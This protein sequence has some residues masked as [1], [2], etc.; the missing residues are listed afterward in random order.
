MTTIAREDRGGIPFVLVVVF[1][2]A[3][4]SNRG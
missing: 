4:V 1:A 2:G 3:V